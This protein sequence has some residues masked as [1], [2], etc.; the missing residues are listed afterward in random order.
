MIRLVSLALLAASQALAC[1]CVGLQS[2]KDAWQANPFVFAGR[3]E[4]AK[5]NLAL[6]QNVDVRVEEA[7]KGVQ[8]DQIVR[9][10]QGVTDCEL[11]FNVGSRVLFYLSL[12]ETTGKWGAGGCGRI[13]PV[14]S[15]G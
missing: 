1:V 3:I 8:K 13:R 5:P 11:R 7:F 10:A 14:E 12:E 6:P 9:L 2:P 4:R 15:A